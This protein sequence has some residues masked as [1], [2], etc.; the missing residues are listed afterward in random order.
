M[1]KLFFTALMLLTISSF[2]QNKT[3]FAVHFD[4]D[5]YNLTTDATASLDSFVNA[6]KA[7]TKIKLYGH[8]DIMAG[9]EYNDALSDKRANAVKNY[10]VNKG[11]T[12]NNIIEEKGFGKRRPLNNNHGEKEMY[13]NRRVEIIVED[14]NNVAAVKSPCDEKPAPTLTEEIEDTSTKAGDN[15]ILK[16]MNFYGGTHVIIPQSM[17]VLMELVTVMKKNPKLE[18]AVE[19]HICCNK[20]STDGLD[21]GTRTMN[22]SENR[23]K[24][25]CNYLWQNGVASHRLKFKGFAHQNPLYAYPE[26]KEEERTM[27]RRVEIKILKK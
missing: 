10:L 5:K 27:N 3:S 26:K 4:T 2:A 18:I 1:K 13:M 15:I 6:H 17:P 22:L 14:D 24:E 25:I 8:C 11:F 20:D 7:D 12:A 19:G 21:F 23:A 9:Y 16:N